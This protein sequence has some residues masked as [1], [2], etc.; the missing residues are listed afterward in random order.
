VGAVDGECYHDWKRA[1]S[2]VLHNVLCT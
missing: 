1:N 2:K